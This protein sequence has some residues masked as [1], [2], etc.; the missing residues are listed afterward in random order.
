MQRLRDVKGLSR[1][2]QSVMLD[3]AGCWLDRRR[4]AALINGT[5]TLTTWIVETVSLGEY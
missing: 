1:R 4:A 2:V 3:V 5:M